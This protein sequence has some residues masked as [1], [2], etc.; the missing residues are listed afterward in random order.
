MSKH[1]QGT[2]LDLIIIGAGIAGIN[3]AYRYQES[4]PGKRSYAVLEARESI[5]GTWDLF[6]YPGIRSDSDI[7][8]FAFQWNPWPRK[9][10]LADGHDIKQYL[11]DSA[12]KTGIIKHI[13]L[14]HKVT[15][16]DWQ[17]EASRWKV[18]TSSPGSAKE[19]ATTLYSRFIYLATGYYDYDEPLQTTIPGIG[20]FQGDVIHPQFWPADYD[21]TGK[22]VVVIGSG[23]TAVTIVPSMTD[24]A[25]HVTM[26]QR[27]PTYIFPL[28]SRGA[29]SSA[30]FAALPWAL[31]YWLHRVGWILQTI[32]MIAACRAWPRLS[33]RYIRY[34]SARLLP[35]G[36]PWD[37]HFNPR[38]KPWEQRLCASK[39]GDIFAALRSG[40]ASVVTD[41]ISAV[42]KNSISLASG[43]TLYPDTIVTATG[44]KLLFAG[45][46]RVTVDGTDKDYAKSFLWKGTMLQ[47]VPNLFFTIG[48]ENAAWTLGCDC[49]ALL[50]VRVIKDMDRQKAR[51]AVPRLDAAS[52]GSMTPKPLF[53]LSAT[54]LQ[55]VNEE[56]P[57][58]GTGVWG[59]RTNYLVDLWKTQYGDVET[60][61]EMR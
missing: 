18:T 1:D 9:E 39:D 24:R 35:A 61:L 31:A 48:F 52:A 6:R 4:S 45:G 12:T 3:A 20:D 2:D 34:E 10:A 22:N 37:P 7:F 30:I 28:P 16:I 17:S 26:L 47:D 55:K 51:V 19:P 60:C 36:V 56:L 41:T 11:I 15:S 27:S 33:R 58:A 43:E 49:A 14:G 50:A 57:K 25:A 40:K 44:L 8:T 29:L 32:F 59:P 53:S 21:Y 46:M 5:G 42:G 38:Y 23:A 13:R 54:Y